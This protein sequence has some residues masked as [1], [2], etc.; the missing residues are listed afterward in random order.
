MELLIV[1]L[2]VAISALYLVRRFWLSFTARPEQGCGEG[3]GGCA[4]SSDHPGNVP[5]TEHACALSDQ[6]IMDASNLEE[7]MK[8][9]DNPN[10][11]QL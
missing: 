10:G 9:S 3:C 1:I 11:V 6:N 4:C 5:G 8:R 2:A 7:C